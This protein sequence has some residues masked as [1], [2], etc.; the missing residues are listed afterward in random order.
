MILFSDKVFFLVA[1]TMSL[2]KIRLEKKT[3]PDEDQDLFCSIK[4]QKEYI[5]L[6]NDHTYQGEAC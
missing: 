1:P 2:K 5:N 3:V 4:T 6:T